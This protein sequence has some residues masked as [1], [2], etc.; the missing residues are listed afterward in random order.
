MVNSKVDDKMDQPTFI[1]SLVFAS[2]ISSYKY[3]FSVFN[4]IAVLN[5]TAVVGT[6]IASGS[7]KTI[8]TSSGY[9]PSSY[10]PTNAV[11]FLASLYNDSNDRW[12]FLTA[13]VNSNGAIYIRPTATIN[14]GDTIRG[15]ISWTY[16]SDAWETG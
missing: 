10:R 1:S 8:L 12:D 4:G 6:S 3:A 14:V 5:F 11:G 15:S 13:Y 9:I 16:D 2:T 7:I